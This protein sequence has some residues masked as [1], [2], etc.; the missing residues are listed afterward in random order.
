MH[1]LH[2][3]TANTPIAFIQLNNNNNNFLIIHT[4]HTSG[5]KYLFCFKKFPN[6]S[7]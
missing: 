2:K 3:S 1:H 4:N 5:F 7:L 6:E